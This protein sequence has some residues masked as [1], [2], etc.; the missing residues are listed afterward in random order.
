MVL[1]VL[2][3]LLYYN[4]LV[5]VYLNNQQ[6]KIQDCGGEGDCFFH[7][8]AKLLSLS[9]SPYQDLS[10]N[11][12]RLREIADEFLKNLLEQEGELLAKE[13]PD[14]FE[15]ISNYLKLHDR[16]GVYADNFLIAAIVNALGIHIRFINSRNPEESYEIGSESSAHTA[17]FMLYDMGAEHY[18][19]LVPIIP[20]S[21]D[22]VI[23]TEEDPKTKMARK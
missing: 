11:H 12:K 14:Y 10:Y 19:A 6:L 22:E 23:I 21:T 13:I 8:L 9:D 1:P 7:V 16:Q 15:Q 5:D 2:F 18:Q 17:G 4:F 3:R 20:E